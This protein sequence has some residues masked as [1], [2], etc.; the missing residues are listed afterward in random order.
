MIAGPLNGGIS[1]V[2]VISGCLGGRVLRVVRL[3]GSWTGGNMSWSLL[4]CCSAFGPEE[5]ILGSIGLK[6]GPFVIWW[7]LVYG[8]GW[9]FVVGLGGGGR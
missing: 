5:A 8:W 2:F 1:G 7:G 6:A 4:G 3:G 9:V